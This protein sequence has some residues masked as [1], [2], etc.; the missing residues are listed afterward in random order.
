MLTARRHGP[1]L[2][3]W[4]I[5]ACVRPAAAQLTPDTERLRSAEQGALLATQLEPYERIHPGV[6]PVSGALI[7]ALGMAGLVA[8]PLTDEF[9]STGFKLSAYTAAALWATGGTAALLA[10][11]AWQPSLLFS[12][13]ESGTGL[14]W[15]GTGFESASS[16][17]EA[18]AQPYL[19]A[20]GTGMVLS[21]SLALVSTLIRRPTPTSQ[22][23]QDHELLRTPQQ[24]AQLTAAELSAIER[25][26][27]LSEPVI[28][29]FVQLVPHWVGALVAGI[30]AAAD[31]RLDGRT[32]A[33]VVALAASVTLPPLIVA[34][35][36]PG[37]YSQYAR[38]RRSLGWDVSVSAGPG[39]AGIRAALLF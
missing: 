22:L 3:C 25:R 18:H 38:K 7:G 2:A 34:I 10:D 31:H 14:M 17:P 30:G 24:R 37:G 6:F 26:F 32:R 29:L 13:I 33:G 20:L 4:L 19:T 1:W 27:K 35:V 15:I 39:M 8:L 5:L 11:E 36:T 9:D 16:H 28:P 21:G 12:A 23:K